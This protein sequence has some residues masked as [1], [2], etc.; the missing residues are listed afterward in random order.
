[1]SLFP[2][3]VLVVFQNSE[4]RINNLDNH[5][6]YALEPAHVLETV[7]KLKPFSSWWLYYRVLQYGALQVL[8]SICSAC[9][10]LEIQ[11]WGFEYQINNLDN[12]RQSALETALVLETVDKL[13]PF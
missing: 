12:H 13:K 3:E 7:D 6:Q 4:Y 9:C 1:M 11:Y 5:R 2:S 10:I 8:V